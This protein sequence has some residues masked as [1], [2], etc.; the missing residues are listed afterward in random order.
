LSYDKSSV[1][2]CGLFWAD[3]VDAA[4]VEEADGEHAV[5]NAASPAAMHQPEESGR[6]MD[7]TAGPEALRERS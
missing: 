7:R 3:A 4:E 5:I 6:G 1:E 2:T